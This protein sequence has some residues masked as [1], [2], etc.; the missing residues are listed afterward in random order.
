MSQDKIS[1]RRISEVLRRET[2]ARIRH[3]HPP[4]ADDARTHPDMDT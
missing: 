2:W 4:Q 1:K 3:D